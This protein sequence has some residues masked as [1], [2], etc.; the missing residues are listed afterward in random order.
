MGSSMIKQQFPG[1]DYQQMRVSPNSPLA[2]QII[3]DKVFDMLIF[4]TFRYTKVFNEWKQ[5]RLTEIGKETQ[6]IL[7]G[8]AS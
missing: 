4:L 3:E 8:A 5:K 7:K 2:A 1:K 6:G